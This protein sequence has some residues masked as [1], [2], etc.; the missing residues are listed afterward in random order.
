MTTI[1]T[2]CNK[3][4]CEVIA[5]DESISQTWEYCFDCRTKEEYWYLQFINS[6]SLTFYANKLE[7]QKYENDC[8]N[9]AG[10]GLGKYSNKEF[11]EIARACV[12]D[13]LHQLKELDLLAC[14][15]FEN[16]SV[17]PIRGAMLI[18]EMEEC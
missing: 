18:K 4:N 8:I 3:C 17:S 6:G 2:R 10:H 11:A 9:N 15:K 12:I 13:L 1:I 16:T 5:P 14:T 7:I